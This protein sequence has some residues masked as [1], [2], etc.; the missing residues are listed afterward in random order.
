VT[1]SATA[2][3]IIH[4]TLQTAD[5]TL[6]QILKVVPNAGRVVITGNA[7]ATAAVNV[8]WSIEE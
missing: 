6:T 5:A 8:C 3:S 1:R 7:G 2:S 4:A